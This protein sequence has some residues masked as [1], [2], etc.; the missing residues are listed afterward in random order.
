[1]PFV[2]SH[3]ETKDEQMVEHGEKQGHVE[4][5]TSSGDRLL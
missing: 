2:N 3:G 5:S 4:T 1:M